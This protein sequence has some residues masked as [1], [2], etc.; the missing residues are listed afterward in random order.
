MVLNPDEMF[1][2]VVENLAYIYDMSYVFWWAVEKY[3]I[4]ITWIWIWYNY[5]IYKKET[6][7]KSYVKWSPVT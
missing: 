5:G 4:L 7:D 3:I 1:N 6:N 2:V